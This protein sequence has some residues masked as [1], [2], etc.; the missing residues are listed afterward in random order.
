MHLMVKIA[1]ALLQVTHFHR[2]RCRYF[3]LI[4]QSQSTE[5][6]SQKIEIGVEK[7]TKTFKIT[8]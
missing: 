2:N 6:D 5:K 1:T 7:S 3:F 8:K 4:H